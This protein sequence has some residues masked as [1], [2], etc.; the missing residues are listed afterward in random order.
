YLDQEIEEGAVDEQL[1]PRLRQALES[2]PGLIARLAE[3]GGDIG[4]EVDTAGA[5]LRR[6]DVVGDRRGIVDAGL[7][8]EQQIEL[9]SL[10][11]Q[12]RLE[13]I[14]GK[15]TSECAAGRAAVADRRDAACRRVGRRERT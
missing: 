2:G 12:I 1:L 15:S 11:R 3:H 9:G 10:G 13:R 6:I 4:E 8:A 5:G 7:H 14:I